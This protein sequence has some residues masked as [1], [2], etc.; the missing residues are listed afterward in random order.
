MYLQS[1]PDVEKISNSLLGR[2]EH[3]LLPNSRAWPKTKSAET[4]FHVGHRQKNCM[5][6]S[7]PYKD[8]HTVEDSSR[9]PKTAQTPLWPT[10]D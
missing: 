10:L 1:P 4:L 6:L 7:Q 8:I 2:I 9:S 5:L 3:G